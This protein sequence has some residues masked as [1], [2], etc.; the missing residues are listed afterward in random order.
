MADNKLDYIQERVDTV[1]DRVADLGK[2]VEGVRTTLDS[3][4]AQEAEWK[5][6]L[7]RIAATLDHNTDSLQEHMRRTDLLEEYVKSV[8]AR[9]T[10]M[11]MEQMR[12]KAVKAWITRQV[13]FVAKLGALV[14][15]G[16]A[17]ALAAKQ[18]IE[19]FLTH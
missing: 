14:S 7:S 15:A 9:F 4:T 6:D 13:K 19:Y 5:Q 11:E 12:K 18:L 3:H 8:D 16:G 10:P 17:L 2:T 1:V